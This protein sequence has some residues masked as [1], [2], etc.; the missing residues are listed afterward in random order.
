MHIKKY[1]FIDTFIFVGLSINILSAMHDELNEDYSTCEAMEG[2][3]MINR[4]YLGLPALPS[5]YLLFYQKG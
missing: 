4:A 5:G 3:P 1:F 2:I